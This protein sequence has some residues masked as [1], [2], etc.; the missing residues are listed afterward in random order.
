MDD[1]A[2]A[3]Q[4]GPDEPSAPIGPLGLA[5]NLARR[6]APVLRDMNEAVE[7]HGGLDEVRE[8]VVERTSHIVKRASDAIAHASAIEGTVIDREPPVSGQGESPVAA[9]LSQH[10]PARSDHPLR[11]IRWRRYG[12]VLCAT[13]IGALLMRQRSR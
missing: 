12:L 9:R 1:S 5:R 8:V 4:P 10:P 13:L 2:D 6:A 3:Q 11:P 7:R